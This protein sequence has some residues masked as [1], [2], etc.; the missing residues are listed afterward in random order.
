MYWCVQC[1]MMKTV[2]PK[3]QWPTYE[4]DR[5]KGRYVRGIVS[6]LYNSGIQTG[7]DSL[8]C[9]NQVYI[10]MMLESSVLGRYPDWVRIKLNL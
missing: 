2:L 10:C 3:D 6:D 9:Q 8:T 5:Q 1:N 7:K 4:E